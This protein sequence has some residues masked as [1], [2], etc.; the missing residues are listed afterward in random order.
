MSDEPEFVDHVDAE[1]DSQDS[2]DLMDLVPD[3]LKRAWAARRE[4][5]ERAEAAERRAEAAEARL[6][7]IEAKIQSGRLLFW[8]DRIGPDGLPIE[9][10]AYFQNFRASIFAPTRSPFG[11]GVEQMQ[12]F[13]AAGLGQFLTIEEAK[14]AA[15]AFLIDGLAPLWGPGDQRASL[16]R[17]DYTFP[18]AKAEGGPS[19]G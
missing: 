6:A 15:E 2:F 4:A 9:T 13:S 17:P 12:P 1:D 18:N 5:D 11:V 7:E 10:R 14:D 8:E 16:D 3:S 19:D